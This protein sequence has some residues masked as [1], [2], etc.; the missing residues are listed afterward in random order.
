MPDGTRVR[1]EIVDTALDQV[2]FL[3]D[4]TGADVF[5]APVVRQQIFDSI[6]GTIGVARQY[7]VV[8]FFLFNGQRGATGDTS[9]RALSAELRDA[10]LRRKRQMPG[11][12]LVLNDRQ[13]RVR[14]LPSA[15]I[16]AM[17]AAGIRWSTSTRRAA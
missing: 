11:L 12:A 3:N 9:A 7:V 10:L 4:V 8:D 15:D 6:L 5:G 13:R 1:G 16:A 17:R 2:E 14:Q